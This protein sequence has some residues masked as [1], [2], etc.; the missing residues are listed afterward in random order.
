MVMTTP[1]EGRDKEKDRDNDRGR[2]WQKQRDREQ[3][4]IERGRVGV[5]K[6]SGGIREAYH[7]LTQP[8]IGTACSWSW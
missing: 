8:A 7:P 3:G 2:V 5:Y 6:G 4:Q 1:V